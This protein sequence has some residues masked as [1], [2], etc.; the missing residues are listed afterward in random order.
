MAAGRGAEEERKMAAGRSDEGE[1]N[2]ETTE[3]KRPAA[4]R[5]QECHHQHLAH[6]RTAGLYD[7]IEKRILIGMLQKAVILLYPKTLHRR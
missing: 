6:R 3:P 7:F 2:R 5:L 1:R 4:L